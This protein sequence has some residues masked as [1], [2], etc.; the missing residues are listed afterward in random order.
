MSLLR[1][2]FSVIVAICHGYVI[3][4]V[5]STFIKQLHPNKYIDILFGI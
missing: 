1:N 3:S 4:S 5:G 2:V